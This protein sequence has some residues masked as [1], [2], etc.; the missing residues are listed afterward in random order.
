MRSWLGTITPCI[1]L[2]GV[3]IFLSYRDDQDKKRGLA[4][5]AKPIPSPELVGGITEETNTTKGGVSGYG[6]EI[7][8]RGEIAT[9]EFSPDPR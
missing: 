5:Q 7:T 2:A 4:E 8:N 6:G 3:L 1:L 9:I